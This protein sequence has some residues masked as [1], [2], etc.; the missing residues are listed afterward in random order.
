MSCSTVVIV[1]CYWLVIGIETADLI[2]IQGSQY[3]ARNR[4]FGR[5]HCDR[6][7]PVVKLRRCHAVQ[8]HLSTDTSTDSP[9]CLPTFDG[10]PGDSRC[11]GNSLC[12]NSA[13]G[14]PFSGNRC[15]Q[16]LVKVSSAAVGFLSVARQGH[17]VYRHRRGDG[18]DLR[19]KGSTQDV[20]HIV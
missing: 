19:G 4:Q 17:G 8:F 6:V 10:L 12:G 18:C 5:G 3:S 2:A 13:H 9:T 15:I 20:Q 11:R 14:R 7:D 1:A 16:P